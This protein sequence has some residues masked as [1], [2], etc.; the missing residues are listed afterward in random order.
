[1]ARNT[2]SVQE[3]AATHGL[4]YKT[5]VLRVSIHC[6]GCKRK[7]SKILLAIH[8]VYT[9]AVDMKKQRVTVTGNVEAETLIT[10][11]SNKGKR[12]S[13]CDNESKNSKS[14]HAGNQEEENNSQK[15]QK[16]SENR[17]A[18]EEEA[19]KAMMATIPDENSSPNK[20]TV[21]KDS[22]GNLSSGEK[23]R[24][25]GKNKTEKEGDQ[26][27]ADPNSASSSSVPPFSSGYNRYQQMT[28]N[29]VLPS[30]YPYPPPQQ[31][32]YFPAAV[33][34]APNPYSLYA[35]QQANP[36]GYQSQLPP[37]QPSMGLDSSLQIFSD[38]NVNGCSVM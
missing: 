7:V 3:E 30:P 11:L 25:E 1:M 4:H 18:H 35:Q 19:S 31:Y 17:G 6:Q 36:F 33:N 23:K 28:T 20:Q 27:N 26:V 38:E 22:P 2:S 15:K 8:G 9:V 13:I 34:A 24:R 14:N 32:F 12:A 29:Q 37:P 10:K 5:W 16:Q 21:A